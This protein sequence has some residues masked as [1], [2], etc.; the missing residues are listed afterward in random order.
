M[1]GPVSAGGVWARPVDDADGGEPGGNIRGP[2]TLPHR[3]SNTP[4]PCRPWSLPGSPT[5]RP[6][7]QT[8][9]ATPTSSKG[10]PRCLTHTLLPGSLAR[11]RYSYDVVHANAEF[12]DQISDHDPQVG[13]PRW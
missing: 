8:L 7:C 5:C 3:S 10:T 9:T 12:A 2:F 1:N 6:G 11:E 4:P 13:L